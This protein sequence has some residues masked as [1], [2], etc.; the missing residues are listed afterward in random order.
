M[1]QWF[2]QC[3]IG[4]KSRAVGPKPEHAVESLCNSVEDCV[5]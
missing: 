1:T 3:S 2:E 4:A 5:N